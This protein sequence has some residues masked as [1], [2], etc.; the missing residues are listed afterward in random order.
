M[1]LN[2]D[3]DLLDRA[4]AVLARGGVVG[5]P[6]E[7]VY[8]L[9][10]RPDRRDAVERLFALK[11]RPASKA[12]S[13]LVPDLETAALAVQLPDDTAG[14]RSLAAACWPGPLTVVLPAREDFVQYVDAGTGKLG[15]RVP[16]HALTLELLRRVGHPLAVP[17]A[18]PSG[19]PSATEAETV[20]AYF[21]DRL[22]VLLD[23]GRCDGGVESTVVDLSV[24][25]PRVLRQGALSRDV[26]QEHLGSLAPLDDAGQTSPPAA[27]SASTTLLVIGE[28]ALSA[29]ERLRFED[30][31]ELNTSSGAQAARELHHWLR[32]LPDERLKGSVWT[33]SPSVDE[34]PQGPGIRAILERYAGQRWRR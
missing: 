4:V 28:L 22:D 13:L 21:G 27:H 23:G 31:F 34:S 33:L 10:V 9:A 5:V 20:A 32:S 7:T 17:S 30:V 8:G 14:L 1:A 24:V 3:D 2:P 18:N 26:L 6:T 19:Q 25:P 11:G 15:V 12:I 29:Q 16:A